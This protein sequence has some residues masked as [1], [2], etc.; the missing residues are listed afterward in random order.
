MLFS[1]GDGAV[2]ENYSF[3]EYFDA[4]TLYVSDF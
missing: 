4:I 1:K 2:S 3:F